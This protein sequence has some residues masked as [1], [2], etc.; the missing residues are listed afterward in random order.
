MRRLTFADQQQ[1]QQVMYKT[2]VTGAS[3]VEGRRHSQ[4]KSTASEKPSSSHRGRVGFTYCVPTELKEFPH[5]V[6][7]RQLQVAL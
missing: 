5:E 3:K 2:N 4:A 6:A 7:C 1:T